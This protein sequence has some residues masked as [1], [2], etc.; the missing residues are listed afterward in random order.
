MAI[1]GFGRLYIGYRL[2]IRSWKKKDLIDRRNGTKDKGEIFRINLLL[3]LRKIEYLCAFLI[4]V[5][6]FFPIIRRIID[7]FIK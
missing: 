6:L 1:I 2:N 4:I 3:I 7:T 5:F